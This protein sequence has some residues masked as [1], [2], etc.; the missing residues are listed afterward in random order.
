MNSAA[1]GE[2]ESGQ[3]DAS[4]P[5]TS[6][7]DDGDTA[8]LDA[9]LEQAQQAAARSRLFARRARMARQLQ[10]QIDLRDKNSE[11]SPWLSP[12]YLEHRKQTLLSSTA[13]ELERHVQQTDLQARVQLHTAWQAR[14]L[15]TKIADEQKVAARQMSHATWALVA[16]TLVLALATVGLIVATVTHQ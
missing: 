4:G 1:E 9:L 7:H 6:A 3:V 16:M 13:N 12:A 10:E 14:R 2:A 8:A 15:E 5:E 11:V